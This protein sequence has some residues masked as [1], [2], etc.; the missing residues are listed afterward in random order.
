[1]GLTEPSL[2]TKLKPFRCLAHCRC[3][4][5]S[6]CCKRCCNSVDSQCGIGTHETTMKQNY[7][8]VDQVRVVSDKCSKHL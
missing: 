1:M 2:S 7:I 6:P 8:T 4:A 3:T 5:K